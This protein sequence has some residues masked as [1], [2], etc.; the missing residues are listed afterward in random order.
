MNTVG[1]VAVN[2]DGMY[3]MYSECSSHSPTQVFS[4][5]WTAMLDDAGIISN[6]S[7]FLKLKWKN[8]DPVDEIVGYINAVAVISRKVTLVKVQ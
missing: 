8:K 3:L 5:S 6:Q 7:K 2:K 1:L 4:F